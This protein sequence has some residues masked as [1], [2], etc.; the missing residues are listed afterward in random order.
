MHLLSFITSKTTL[1][2]KGVENTIQLLNQDCTIPFISRY[3][4]EHTGNLDEVQIGEIVKYKQ[5]FEE[6]E[7]R[8]ASILKTLKDQEILTDELKDKIQATIDLNALEDLYLPFKRKTKTKAEKAR[9]NGLEP[10]AKIIMSQKPIQL[11]QIV[12]KY[13]SEEIDSS[14]ALEGARH[15]IAEWIN[16]RTSVR[17]LIRWHLERFAKIRTKI[18]PSKAESDKALKFR[19]YFNWEEALKGCPSHRLLAILRAE[20]EGFIREGSS[21]IKAK[22]P[23]IFPWL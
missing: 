9:I 15:I 2:T 12:E 3:R 23:I 10:L 13:T 4:K 14:S 16:E 18:V 11:Q 17:N 5:L 22:A 19:D 7:K 20:R 8:R 1:P 6:L 21:L